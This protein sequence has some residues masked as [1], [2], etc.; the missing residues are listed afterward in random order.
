[1]RRFHLLSSLLFLCFLIGAANAQPFPVSVD[2]CGETLTFSAPP[3][4]A[5]FHDMN[6]TEMGLEPGGDLPSQA[7]STG[8]TACPLSAAWARSSPPEN[9][10]MS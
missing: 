8:A 3:K 7:V 1:M 9:E 4:A 6:M 10:A 2:S 5:V